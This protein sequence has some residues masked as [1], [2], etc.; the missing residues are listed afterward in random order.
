M[1][2]AGFAVIDVETTGFSPKRG[3]RI[4]EIAI[5]HVSPSGEVEDVWESLI[6]PG[7]DVG[8]TRIHG[9][10]A[11]HVVD[12]PRFVELG[13]RILNLLANRVL[14]AHNLEFDT[15]FLLAELREVDDTLAISWP[16]RVDFPS[17]CTMRLASEFFPNSARSL[18]AC[19]TAAGIER[20]VTH[21]AAADARDTALLL[22]H[23]WSKSSANRY[24]S[25]L[26]GEAAHWE[27]DVS[28][29]AAWFPREAASAP[30]RH[31][32]ERIATTAAPI[33]ASA[34]ELDYLGILDRALLDGH[35]SR[36]EEAELVD[37]AHSLG[38]PRNALEHLHRS[39]LHRMIAAA[40]ADGVLTTSELS[41][42]ESLASALGVT[43][44][45]FGEPSLPPITAPPV[46]SSLAG[47]SFRLEAGDT[48]VLTG[49]MFYLRDG[50]ASYLA[51]LGILIA[52][53]ASRKVKLAVAADPDS[54]SGKARKARE[55][56]I[57]IVTEAK[58][59]ELVGGHP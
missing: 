27:F 16:G 50:W 43:D 47:G 28:S 29:A 42:L 52:A 38:L 12:A 36:T 55:L 59:I 3:D 23:Y 56:Q 40:W 18:D 5:V 37:V 45:A 17:A 1:P 8:P 19:C 57:P 6:D 11:H 39:Y 33:H 35:L 25:D 10:E 49:D 13:P 2:G 30:R 26:I 34:R 20:S 46:S 53:N 21:R 4:V 51:G 58:L 24:W 48:V 7:R 32:V 31:F 15:R 22:S 41:E 44:L 14:V 9:I 54:Q